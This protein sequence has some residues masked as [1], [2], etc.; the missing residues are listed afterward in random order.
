MASEY[1]KPV[2]AKGFLGRLSGKQ[3]MSYALNIAMGPE[4]VEQVDEE[5]RAA[6]EAIGE[7]CDRRKRKEYILF[8]VFADDAVCQALR[9]RLPGI[10][11]ADERL[12]TSLQGIEIELSLNGQEK[13][14]I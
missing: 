2:R 11:R 9:T 14:Q 6:A 13:V 12:S 4:S 3:E 10:C 5:L 8:T 7:W 1:S